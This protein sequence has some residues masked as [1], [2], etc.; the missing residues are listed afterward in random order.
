MSKFIDLDGVKST[1]RAC[2][3]RAIS[4]AVVGGIDEA[5]ENL[6]PLTEL[7]K[8]DMITMAC[9]AYHDAVIEGEKAL[10]GET[11]MRQLKKQYHEK[12]V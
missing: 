4:S 5:S 8:Q 9:M 3:S 1:F 10:E 12:E 7:Q 6:R 11:M 2:L